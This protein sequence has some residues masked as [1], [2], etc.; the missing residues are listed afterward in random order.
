MQ[1]IRTVGSGHAA[2]RTPTRFPTG[3]CPPG[4]ARARP[5]APAVDDGAPTLDV[6][7]EM[8]DAAAA[9]GIR[10]IVATP[11]LT[12]AL[13]AEYD[14]LVRGAFAQVEPH[15]AARGIALV[16]GF[17]IRLTPDTP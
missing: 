8:L 11:H 1:P 15:A 4:V 3:R 12:K 5:A 14:A 6:S 17:E 2:R 13:D 7:I 16:P 9:I 10:T